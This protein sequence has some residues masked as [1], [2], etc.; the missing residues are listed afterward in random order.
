MLLLAEGLEFFLFLVFSEGFIIFDRLKLRPVGLT[1]GIKFRFLIGS[2][3][4]L[5]GELISPGWAFF[6]A[7]MTF[8]IFIPFFTFFLSID[9]LFFK[10][11]FLVGGQNRIELVLILLVQFLS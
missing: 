4:Q 1:H 11:R 3:I 2:K 6:S 8:K 5:L 10:P 7:F 9:L